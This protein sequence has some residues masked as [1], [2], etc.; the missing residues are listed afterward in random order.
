LSSTMQVA[1]GFNI[2]TRPKLAVDTTT[3]DLTSKS[4]CTSFWTTSSTCSI[5]LKT[6]ANTG[7]IQRIGAN[8]VSSAVDVRYSAVSAPIVTTTTIGTFSYGSNLYSGT[9]S[10]KHS[11]SSGSLCYG[12]QSGTHPIV[13]GTIGNLFDYAT[14]LY[15]PVTVTVK[16]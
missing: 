14:D 4:G 2:V 16:C 3:V 12:T 5:S 6:I 13:S 7:Y 9:V 1:G 11:T 10:I 8:G 15:I